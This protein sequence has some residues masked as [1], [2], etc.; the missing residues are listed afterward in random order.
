M[1]SR[2]SQTS[3]ATLAELGGLPF[4]SRVGSLL[5]TRSL[6]PRQAHVNPARRLLRIAPHSPAPP[7]TNAASR[8]PA[9]AV[10]KYRQIERVGS[11]LPTLPGSEQA[12]VFAA[13]VEGDRGGHVDK[14]ARRRWG[15]Q[16]A[17]CPSTDGN[18]AV[19]D[20]SGDLHPRRLQQL[21]Q[22]CDLGAGTAQA[23]QERGLAG[24]VRADDH[25]DLG[26]EPHRDGLRAE[27]AEAGW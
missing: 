8:A 3:I 22:G 2:E 10:L 17:I 27:A 9:G 25:R 6:Q 20:H 14:I 26:R 23:V 7:R 21:I 13:R 18:G 4:L 11:E 15:A 1:D 19:P 12:P 24:R 16:N 5:P